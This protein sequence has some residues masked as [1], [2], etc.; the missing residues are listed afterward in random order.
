MGHTERLVSILSVFVCFDYL[1]ATVIL[2]QELYAGR[3]DLHRTSRGFSR[4]FLFDQQVPFALFMHADNYKL[5]RKEKINE[6]STTRIRLL[7]LKKGL[8]IHVL[9]CFSCRRGSLPRLCSKDHTTAECKSR[10]FVCVMMITV[11]SISK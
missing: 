6:P 1:P 11:M 2:Y 5:R 8:S 7:D 10:L 3:R 4:G 9:I